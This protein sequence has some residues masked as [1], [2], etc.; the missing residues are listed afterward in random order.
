MSTDLKI[1]IDGL[2]LLLGNATMCIPSKHTETVFQDMAYKLMEWYDVSRVDLRKALL[3]HGLHL[4]ELC[5]ECN[6]HIKNTQVDPE[7]NKP[8]CNKCSKKP[9]SSYQ[10][11]PHRD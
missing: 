11:Q 3:I 9:L 2:F 4:K 5:Y 7:D 6:T 10:I 8:L 1:D